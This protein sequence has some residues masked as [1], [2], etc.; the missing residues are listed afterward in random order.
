MAGLIAAV[1]RRTESSLTVANPGPTTAGTS[2]GNPRTS[3]TEAEAA[4]LDYQIRVGWTPEGYRLVSDN[5]TM[6]TEKQTAERSIVFTHTSPADELDVL[7]ERRPSNARSWTMVFY[8]ANDPNTDRTVTEIPAKVPSGQVWA[9][10]GEGKAGVSTSKVV[11]YEVDDT[12]AVA[13][14]SRTQPTEV[15]IGVAESIQLDLP[16]CFPASGTRT[17]GPCTS[18]QSPAAG[19]FG[20]DPTDT[21]TATTVPKPCPR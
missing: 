21:R 7:R 17:D 1:P 2:A 6:D 8:S 20:G 15:L 3:T 18:G 19:R 11:V 4:P 16:D 13:V 12:T 14:E 5:R 9:F 10:N